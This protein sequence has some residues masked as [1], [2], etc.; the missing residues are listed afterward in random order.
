MDLGA[1]SGPTSRPA[2]LT[3]PGAPE[4]QQWLPSL[5]N[6]K[7]RPRERAQKIMVTTVVV[8]MGLTATMMM[9]V[10]TMTTMVTMTM[11]MTVVTDT[12]K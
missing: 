8:A 10:V 1:R 3:P 9:T 7:R 4:G 6:R 12:G 2:P 11:V 5:T